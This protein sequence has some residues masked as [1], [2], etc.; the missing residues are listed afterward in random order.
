[1]NK[2]IEN[3]WA[4]NQNASSDDFNVIFNHEIKKWFSQF[5]LSNIYDEWERKN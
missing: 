5:D 3:E 1:M 2:W 4:I